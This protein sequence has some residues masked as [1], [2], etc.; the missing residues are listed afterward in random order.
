MNNIATERALD[1]L[2]FIKEVIENTNNSILQLSKTFI[3]LGFWF[4]SV[5]IFDVFFHSYLNNKLSVHTLWIIGY[6]FM[7]ISLPLLILIFV[8]AFRTP[9]SGI[10]KQVATMWVFV[11][12]LGLL[13]SSFVNFFQSALNMQHLENFY[14]VRALQLLAYSFGFLFMSVLSKLKLPGVF[15]IVYF[16][17]GF[18]LILPNHFISNLITACFQGISFEYSAVTGEISDAIGIMVAFTFLIIGYYLN[19]KMARSV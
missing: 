7:A 13:G 18:F 10:G 16:I 1:D 4:L 19:Y 8:K 3:Y 15:A 6:I 2:K 14:I 17:F 12:L 9:L 11:F 5:A